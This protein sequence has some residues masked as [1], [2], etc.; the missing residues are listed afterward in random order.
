M[1]RNSHPSASVF[2]VSYWNGCA[3]WIET[4]LSS[5]W[6]CMAKGCWKNLT[7]WSSLGFPYFHKECT[8]AL[9]TKYDRWLMRTF[10][11]KGSW[12]NPEPC[13]IE[14]QI[15]NRLKAL[16]MAEEWLK[17]DRNWARTNFN[18][19][20]YKEQVKKLWT[21][22]KSDHRVSINPQHSCTTKTE[23]GWTVTS[24]HE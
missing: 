7:K 18:L 2:H 21:W 6:H 10:G 20:P 8:H 23:Q 15:V 19:L 13:K 1:L 11:W 3:W 14:V 17:F 16:T 5:G 12:H 9:K 24:W 22:P 4:G